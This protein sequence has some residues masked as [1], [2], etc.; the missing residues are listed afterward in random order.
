MGIVGSIHN[1]TTLVLENRSF[2]PVKSIEAIIKEKCT[3]LYGTP[4]MWVCI[5]TKN[6]KKYFNNV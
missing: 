1:G 6:V 2:N 4:T 5:L 3:V